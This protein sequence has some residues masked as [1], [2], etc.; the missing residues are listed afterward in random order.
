MSCLVCWRSICFQKTYG[1]WTKDVKSILGLS[2]RSVGFRT[3][4]L[5]PQIQRDHS[6]LTR[7]RQAAAESYPPCRYCAGMCFCSSCVCA[8]SPLQE[9]LDML[10][11]CQMPQWS[12]SCQLLSSLG[13]TS[14]DSFPTSDSQSSKSS[15]HDTNGWR[16]SDSSLRPWYW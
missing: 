13:Q 9:H 11:V 3:Y 15:T 1:R 14:D 5:P 4:C 16:L 12:S 6:L 2:I 10:M 8:G 7:W